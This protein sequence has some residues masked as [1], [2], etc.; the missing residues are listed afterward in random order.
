MHSICFFVLGHKT[1]SIP[2][3]IMC[4]HNYTQTHTHTC[5]QFLMNKVHQSN[6]GLVSS[7]VSSPFPSNM[8]N[9]SPSNHGCYILITKTIFNIQFHGSFLFQPIGIWTTPLLVCRHHRSAAFFLFL[10]HVWFP[11]QS[12]LCI[13]TPT[14]NKKD[15]KW[16]QECQENVNTEQLTN[17]T[18]QNPSWE[19]S[20][21]SAR[22]EIH[23]MLWNLKADYHVQNS[24]SPGLY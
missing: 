11:E 6:K 9:L 7:A 24:L 15:I 8:S 17:S 12:L 2:V 3:C 10:C 20:S 5:T 19:V 14:C 13:L 4:T 21:C 18:E 16:G 22:Q 23:Y 1:T